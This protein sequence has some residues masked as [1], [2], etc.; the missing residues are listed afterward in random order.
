MIVAKPVIEGKYWIIK[1][2]D[3]KIGEVE[4]QGKAFDVRI[5]GSVTT[6]KNI[7]T[8]VKHHKV[9]FE[10]RS[11]RMTTTTDA[12]MGYPTKGR[13]HNPTFNVKLK[14]PLFTKSAVSKSWH[15]AGWYKI[16]RDDDEE[17][18]FCPK[19]IILQRYK[20][21]GPFRKKDECSH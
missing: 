14:L 4:K 10:R 1:D 6:H 19:L 11:E 2:G 13:A 3:L 18:E 9:Q 5:N 16:V 12:L 15:A 7:A 8:I 20:F 17:W 21:E